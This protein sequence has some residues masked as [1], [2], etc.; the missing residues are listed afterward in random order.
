M[1]SFFYWIQLS[2][3]QYAYFK[4]N[5]CKFCMYVIQPTGDCAKSNNI[6]LITH[7]THFQIAIY[8]I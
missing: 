1:I 6:V 5:N 7:K 4:Y 3:K 2:V 8:V